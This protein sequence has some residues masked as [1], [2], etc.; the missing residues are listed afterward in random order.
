MST[1]TIAPDGASG[2]PVRRSAGEPDRRPRPPAPRGRA[3]PRLAVGRDPADRR[4]PRRDRRRRHRDPRSCRRSPTR[5]LERRPDLPPDRRPGRPGRRGRAS[6]SRSAAPRSRPSR[7]AWAPGSSARPTGP[8]VPAFGVAQAS[9]IV[10]LAGSL[11]AE[12]P[13]RAWRRRPATSTAVRTLDPVP[14]ATDR[15]RRRPRSAPRHDRPARRLRRVRAAARPAGRP[16]GRPGRAGDRGRRRGQHASRSRRRRAGC[17]SVGTGFVVGPSYVVTNAHVVAGAADAVARPGPAAGS[18][19]RCRSCSIRS[20]T[21]PCST[22]PGLRVTAL[23]FAAAGPEPR[24][25][26]CDPRL[27]RAAGG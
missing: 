5:W 19:T 16:A 20:W 7:G 11:L 12:V 14:A 10:W 13:C 21:S 3:D 27:S 8:P 2:R 26:R 15:D 25:P 9:S 6:A 17:P 1:P 18:S 22:S 24:R 23:Q 4:A